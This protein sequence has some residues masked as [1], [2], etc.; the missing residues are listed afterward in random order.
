MSTVE[1]D[2]I[3]ARLADGHVPT[4]A[5]AEALAST[6]D[7]V[8]LGMVAD[9][10]RRARHGTRTTFL[11]VAQVSADAARSGDLTWPPSAR[12]VRLGGPFV[13]IDRARTAVRAVAAAGAGLAIAGY[14]LA[15]LEQAAAGD[16]SVV[17]RWLDDLREAGLNLI[18][19]APIDLLGQPAALLTAAAGAGVPAA[20]VTVHAAPVAGPLP[21]IRRVAT[22]Q[23]ETDAVRVFAP[24]PRQPGAE[25]TTGYQDVKT[26]ALARLLLADVPHI[27][28]DWTHHGPKLAQVALTFGADDMDNVSARDE[29]AEGRRRAP[30]EEIRRNIRAAG[31][32]AVERDSRFTIVG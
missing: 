2:D 14:S 23:A 10:V 28:A 8:S 24:I 20:R 9:D 17:R 16:V 7:I 4:D 3:A 12:E 32:E 15:E 25:P 29:V 31:F 22:L 26:V 6:Y 13:D 30:L 11:R 5:D 19:E 18:D 1:L 27:Q 21:L